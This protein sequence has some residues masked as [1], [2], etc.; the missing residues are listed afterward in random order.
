MTYEDRI[1]QER[2]NMSKSFAKL[3]DFLLNS[4]IEAA[5]MTASELAQALNLDAATVVRFSQYMGYDGFPKLQREIRQR[6]KDDLLLRPEQAKVTDSL[7][8]IASDAMHEVSLTLERTRMSLD[9]TAFE[10]LVNQIGQAK[11]I[12]V[13][14]ES[15]AQATAYSLVL[16]LEQ[17]SFPVYIARSGISD[18]ARMVNNA[19]SHDLLIAMEVAGQAPYIAHA[20]NEAR[21]RGV[22]TAAIVSSASM[23]SA[24]FVDVVLAAQAHPSIG[25]GIVSIEAI[26]Y[27]LAQVLNWR[28]TDRFAGSDQAILKL[29]ESIRQPLD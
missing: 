23:P 9:T 28:F 2:S 13:L 15:Q 25:L 16:Y 7:P 3:A 22:P 11:R 14:A 8:A 29:T 21:N 1:R 12:V 18:L 5:F 10:K 26:V 19:T 24:R 27:A 17:G 20:M 6:V 4:Y